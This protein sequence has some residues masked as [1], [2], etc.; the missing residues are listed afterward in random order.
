M[1][2]SHNTGESRT[3]VH[4]ESVTLLLS[5][6]LVT[7]HLRQAFSGTSPHLILLGCGENQIRVW[8]SSLHWPQLCPVVQDQDHLPWEEWGFCSFPEPLFPREGC[9]GASLS[10]M[11]R[12]WNEGGREGYFAGVGEI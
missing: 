5:Q 11:N 3:L 4:T 6:M 8:A 2:S 1:L 10:F 9:P 7:C 12:G